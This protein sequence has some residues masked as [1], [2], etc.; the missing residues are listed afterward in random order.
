VLKLRKV[1]VL[2]GWGKTISDS[3]LQIG[4]TI[5]TYHGWR[6]EY[7]GMSGDQ[8]KRLRESKAENQSRKR[9]VADLSL[10]K[11]ILADAV[12]GSY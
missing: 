10:D 3:V 11:M 8:L 2:Q 9:V 4:V 1:E 6:N 12:R 7:G 5:Q